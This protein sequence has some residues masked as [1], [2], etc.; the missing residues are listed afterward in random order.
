MLDLFNVLNANPVLVYNSTY[1][2]NGSSWLPQQSLQARLA[3]F[4]I[5]VNF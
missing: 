2:T 5:Q 3:K 1:G 4:E